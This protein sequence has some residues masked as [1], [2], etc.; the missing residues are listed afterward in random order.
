MHRASV[1]ESVR[2]HAKVP[3]STENLPRHLGS[4]QWLR[5]IGALAVVYFHAAIQVMHLNPD[6]NIPIVGATG[7]DVFFVLSGFIMW[8]TTRNSD[9]STKGFIVKRI[10]RI[11][12]LYWFLTIAVSICALL[13]PHLLRSTR[14]DPTH[15]LTSLLFIPWPNPA[16]VPG[17][18]EYLSPVIVPGWT[19]NM[20][21]VFYLLFSFCLPFRKG[22]RV[23]SISLLIT[24]LYVVGL[25]GAKNGSIASFYGDTVIF[26]FLMGVVL[27]AYLIPF[28][29]LSAPWAWGLLALSLIALV[30]IEAARLDLP[31]AVK[32]GLPAFF[33]IAAAINLERLSAIPA[34]PALVKLGDASY[35]IYLSHIFALAGLRMIVGFLDIDLSPL[36]A[37]AFIVIGLAASAILG[38]LIHQ[39]VE[40]RLSRF[41]VSIGRRDS[42]SGDIAPR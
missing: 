22:W 27:A 18:D 9:V 30:C 25:V 32:F 39:Y 29:R 6:T 35:S 14:F 12:P 8:V 34:F 23:V 24:A 17:T 36:A 37:C 21:M 4:L 2:S 7:V 41:K 31:R 26:E 19:L 5:A 11:A 42:Q 40:K 16:E 13:I 38:L 3:S 33:A 1:K 20:E 15:I 28:L 10:E